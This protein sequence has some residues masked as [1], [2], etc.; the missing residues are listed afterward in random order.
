VAEAKSWGRVW[1]D[2]GGTHCFTSERAAESSVL[3]RPPLATLGRRMLVPRIA[4]ARASF[5]VLGKTTLYPPY[6]IAPACHETES[7]KGHWPTASHVGNYHHNV[8]CSCCRGR[9]RDRTTPSAYSPTQ[10]DEPAYAATYA[11]VFTHMLIRWG[12]DKSG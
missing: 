7:G 10:V 3:D 6:S 11:R 5:A 1:R 12:G 9:R 4:S 8:Y 2:V